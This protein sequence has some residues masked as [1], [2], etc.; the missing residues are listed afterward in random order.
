MKTLSVFLAA[1][2]RMGHQ[3]LM[4]LAKSHKTGV[5]DLQKDEAFIF[6][7]R[8]RT[9]M[10]SYA[11]NHVV[12]FVRS[13][14]INRPIDISCLD[15]LAKSF[16]SDGSMDYPR[17]LKEMLEKKLKGTK[18]ETEYINGKNVGTFLKKTLANQS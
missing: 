18:L 12:S 4:A 2:M 14:D 8:K 5:K 15:Y 13:V 6:I 11:W 9:M 3:G 7:N 17:A 10:K 16:N 1:D